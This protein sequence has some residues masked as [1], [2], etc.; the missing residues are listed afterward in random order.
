[1]LLDFTEFQIIKATL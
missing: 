1:L